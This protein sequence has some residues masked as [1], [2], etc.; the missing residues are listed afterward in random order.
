MAIS[1][2]KKNKVFTLPPAHAPLF[3]THAHLRSF[4]GEDKDPI[5]VLVRAHESGVHE[6][7][8]DLSTPSL[9]NRRRLPMPRRSPVGCMG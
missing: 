1:F 8:T 2:T 3:D 4:W 9:I 6:L 5:D 7:M